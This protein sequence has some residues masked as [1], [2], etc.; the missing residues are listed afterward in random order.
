MENIVDEVIEHVQTMPINL[1][2]EVL[3]FI[4]R[5]KM[6]SPVG[7]SGKELLKFSGAIPIDELETM[8]LAI[9]SGCEQVDLNEW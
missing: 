7:T 5:L 2:Q 4:K 1:Q 8:R 6:S 3:R 9:E